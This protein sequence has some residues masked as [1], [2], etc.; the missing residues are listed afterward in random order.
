MFLLIFFQVGLFWHGRAILYYNVCI[1]FQ[2][3]LNNNYFILV[4]VF[5]GKVCGSTFWSFIFWCDTE[6]FTYRPWEYTSIDLD[7]EEEDAEAEEDDEMEEEE[8]RKL[9]VLVQGWVLDFSVNSNFL[10]QRVAFHGWAI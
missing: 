10:S 5:R 6:P 1:Y 9:F 2:E 4:T 8:V 7:E 3:S